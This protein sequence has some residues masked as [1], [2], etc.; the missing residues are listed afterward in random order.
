MNASE[1]EASRYQDEIMERAG[2]EFCG[3]CL[4]AICPDTG[5]CGCDSLTDEDRKMFDR[6]Q[7]E[8]DSVGC[9]DQ[10]RETDP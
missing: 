4:G 6:L 5:H 1:D 2:V 3:G 10:N 7:Y 9:R 8:D